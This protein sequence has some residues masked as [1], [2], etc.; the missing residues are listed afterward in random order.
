MICGIVDVAHFVTTHA[1]AEHDLNTA[2]T[3]TQP[4]AL[5]ALTRRFPGLT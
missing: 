5:A 3:A 1:L 2:W 4:S